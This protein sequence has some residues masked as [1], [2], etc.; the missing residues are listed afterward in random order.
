MI[1]ISV[2]AEKTMTF[3]K[4]GELEKLQS[5]I[6]I[7]YNLLINRKGAGN[8][9]LGWLDLPE[10]TGNDLLERIMNDAEKIIS[11]SEVLVVVG[12]G[13]SY[14]G[15]RALIEALG[16]NF[17]TFHKGK[18]LQIV[19][20]G[21]NIS[22]EYHAELMELL[23]DKD[24]SVVVISKSGTTIEPAIAFRLLKNHLEEKYGREGAQRRI[25]AITD[26]EKG[27]LKQLAEAE[28]YSTYVIPN[29]VGGRYCV[30]TPVGLL[31]VAVAGF[32][33][34]ELLKGASEMKKHVFASS[35]INEN[36]ALK[37]AAVRTALYRA[38][39]PIEIMVCY[40]PSLMIL[41]EWW[42]QLFGESEGKQNRGIF[43]AG[44]IFTTDL[45]S[46]GQYIQEGLR[47]LFE[48]VV[49]VDKP[50]RDMA[51]PYDD[52]DA[53]GL[54]YIA[55]KSMNEVNRIAELGTTLAHVDGGVPN[56]RI[57][58][59]VVNERN[60]GQLIYFFE[61][62]CAMSGYMLGVNP[63]DQPGVEAYKK[64]MFALLGKKGYE[65]EEEELKKR[66]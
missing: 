65:K 55:G 16:N 14:L 15:A 3:L 56:I 6:N 8:E 19:Y 51:I 20:A 61:F 57:G 34:R 41:T 49:S 39:K 32:N 48:T 25:I 63:F 11:Q 21:Q 23:D 1:N 12:I 50:R 29:D 54:N 62:A 2:N 27:A 10:S 26:A 5:E 4:P 44:N 35:Q 37:Y 59:P 28:P 47:V 17:C 36:I 13:G 24:Y 66:I 22:G 31:P 30:L 42:K 40:S 33:I 18:H 43:P 53:D 52:L 38:G 58:L 7:H 46:M 64:N 45:H 9:F 60:L